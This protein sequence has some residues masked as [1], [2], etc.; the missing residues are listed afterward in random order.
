MP[1]RQ[2]GGGRRGGGRA[3][4][5]PEALERERAEWEAEKLLKGD[6]RG[7]WLDAEHG[8]IGNKPVT[9]ALGW[10]TREGEVLLADGHVSTTRPGPFWD[11]GHNHYGKGQGPNANVKDR[12]MYSGPGA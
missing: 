12:G 4:T 3:Y 6:H 9:F 1:P 7:G 5:I 8:F 10:G 11:G 2:S